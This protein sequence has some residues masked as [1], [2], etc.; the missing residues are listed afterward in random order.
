M[1]IQHCLVF[2]LLSAKAKIVIPVSLVY[3]V[4]HFGL[5]Y[6]GQLSE[7]GL[8]EHTYSNC[9]WLNEN[10]HCDF[11]LIAPGKVMKV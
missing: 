2:T 4:F 8:F 1:V 5:P 7:S 10:F 11:L 3:I 9:V 6:N